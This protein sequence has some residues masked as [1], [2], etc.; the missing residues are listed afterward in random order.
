MGNPYKSKVKV[1]TLKAKAS[2]VENTE[3]DAPVRQTPEGSIS[4]ILEWVGDDKSRAETA[5]IEEMDGKNRKTLITSL[6]ELLGE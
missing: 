3:P 1:N 6:N 5:L 4:E 2:K